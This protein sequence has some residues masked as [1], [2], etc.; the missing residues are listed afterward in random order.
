M[1]DMP[2][3]SYQHQSVCST[4]FPPHSLSTHTY[5]L[6]LEEYGIQCFESLPN[7]ANAQ[8]YELEESQH[9]SQIPE[10]SKLDAWS[11][12]VNAVPDAREEIAQSK[13]PRYPSVP[14]IC[15]LGS[16]ACQE[17]VAM[18]AARP[19]HSLQN[20]RWYDLQV[21]QQTIERSYRQ[22]TIRGIEDLG[23]RLA[24]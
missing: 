6:T 2:V 14:M 3:T 7:I 10:E 15:H 21:F 11:R 12:N 16:L 23:P 22:S 8:Y 24:I 17:S 18:S 13:L 20:L 9:V 1:S 5:G 4:A 19:M